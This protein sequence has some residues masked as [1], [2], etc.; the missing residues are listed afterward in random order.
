ME[1]QG[2]RRKRREGKKENR[3]HGKRWKEKKKE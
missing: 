2:K 3:T 1:R